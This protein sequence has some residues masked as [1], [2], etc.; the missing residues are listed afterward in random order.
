MNGF[1]FWKYIPTLKDSTG[2]FLLAYKKRE[3]EIQIFHGKSNFVFITSSHYLFSKHLAKGYSYG[4][5][6]LEMS[7][8]TSSVVLKVF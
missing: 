5:L 8:S 6:N 4:D 2:C 1:F 3:A 7:Y